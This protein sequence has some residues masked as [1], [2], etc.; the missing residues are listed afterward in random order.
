[1]IAGFDGGAVEFFQL[2]KYIS[3]IGFDFFR[4]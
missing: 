2:T 4:N 3:E 1:M